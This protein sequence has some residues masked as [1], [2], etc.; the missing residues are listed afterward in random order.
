L[1]SSLFLAKYLQRLQNKQTGSFNQTNKQTNNPTFVLI[2]QHA[3][4]KVA[5]QKLENGF[6]ILSVFFFNDI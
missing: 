1:H 4:S 5:N 3:F 2:L 6:T